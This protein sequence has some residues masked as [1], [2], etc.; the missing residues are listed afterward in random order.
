MSQIN[1]RYPLSINNKI[2][3]LVNMISN[4]R[5]AVILGLLFV[6]NVPLLA[7]KESVADRIKLPTTP[8][9]YYTQQNY[10]RLL[11]LDKTLASR[12]NFMEFGSFHSTISDLPKEVTIPVVVHVLYKA[13]SDTK[14]L[15][16]ESDIK[17][18][19]NQSSKDFRQTIKIEK[20]LADTKEKFSDKNALDTKISFCLASKDPA[21]RTTSGV[22]T[23]PT[24]VTSWLADDKMKSAST[25]GSTAWDTEKYLNIWVVNM[26]DSISAYAQYP[27]GSALTD[28]IVIDYRYF[29]TKNKTDK[30]FP[31]TDGKTLTHLIGNYLNL[32]DL[33]SE[34]VLCGDDGVEDTPIHNAPTLGFVD[35]RHI[36]TCDGNP[37]AMSMNFM[38]NTNDESLYMFTTGQKR[39]MIVCLLENGARYKLAQSGET[40][41]SNAQALQAPPNLV[42]NTPTV[43]FYEPLTCRIYPNPAEDM[44]TLDIGLAKEGET[45]LL[46]TN[47]LGNIVLTQKLKLNE[48]SQQVPINCSQWAVGL[49]FVRL[50]VNDQILTERIVINH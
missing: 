28:G 21:G 30:K 5:I 29:G 50:K 41:C 1:K 39:R 24:S 20:H 15:P 2:S 11:L 19:L 46:V 32:Y 45:E 4:N 22:L 40:Q 26:P 48:G 33:W 35:Y 34:T 25:G 13:G 36:S 38:D 43:K 23:V 47:T 27:G 17:N 31:Y 7:Q 9:R 14:L 6:L 42:N 44:I 8:R 49:Y 18:Q 3:Q 12:R 37:V 10:Q 16:T